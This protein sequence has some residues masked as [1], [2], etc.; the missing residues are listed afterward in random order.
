MGAREDE[1]SHVVVLVNLSSLLVVEDQIVLRPPNELS[2]INYKAELCRLCFEYSFR[3]FALVCLDFDRLSLL[4]PSASPFALLFALLC[5]AASLS[6]VIVN[7]IINIT[8]RVAARFVSRRHSLDAWTCKDVHTSPDSFLSM[9]LSESP[10]ALLFIITLRRVVLFII[11][12]FIITLFIIVC[13]ALHYHASP[14]RSLD[15]C[16]CNVVHTSPDPLSA[17][18][19]PLIQTLP[20]ARA[21]EAAPV[22]ITKTMVQSPLLK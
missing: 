7:A 18:D 14:R 12:L 20:P 6:T 4:L 1:T 5:F 19:A 17:G 11:T 9:S 10:F 16:T 3:F 15:A 22:T 13:F 2:K 8:V 21:A